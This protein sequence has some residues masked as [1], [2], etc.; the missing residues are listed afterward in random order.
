MRKAQ[1]IPGHKGRTETGRNMIDLKDKNQC[2]VLEKI[3]E[4]VGNPVF[5]QFCLEVKETYNCSEKIEYSSCS[6]EPGWNIKFKKSGKTLCTIYPRELYF[7]VMIVVVRKEKEAVEAILPECTSRMQE[8]YHETKEGNGQM[9]S[10][11]AT[12]LWEG[13]LS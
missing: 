3:G 2:P 13:M 4:Y 6:M 9:K 12:P 11:D 8:I 5:M 7:I 10:F 1:E